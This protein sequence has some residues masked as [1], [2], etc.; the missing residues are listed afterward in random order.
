MYSSSHPLAFPWTMASGWN[1]TSK[2]AI[3]F[4][5]PTRATERTAFVW[6]I[7]FLKSQLLTE[8]FVFEMRIVASAKKVK[9]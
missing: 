4:G 8:D 2:F 1:L 6:G 5:D 3:Y 7:Q 9:R